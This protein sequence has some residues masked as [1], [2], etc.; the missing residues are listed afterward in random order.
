MNGAEEKREK[1][2][3]RHPDVEFISNGGLPIRLTFEKSEYRAYRYD[4][5]YEKWY[6]M[7][8]G[9]LDPDVLKRYIKEKY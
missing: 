1:M 8:L 6:D 9:G 2:R 5:Q 7:R 3:N 4:S